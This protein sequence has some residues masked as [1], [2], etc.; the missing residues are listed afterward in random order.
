MG[1]QVDLKGQDGDV[2]EIKDLFGLSL[3]FNRIKGFVQ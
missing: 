2:R 3:E 1:S